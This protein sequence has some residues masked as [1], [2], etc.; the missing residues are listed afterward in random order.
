MVNCSKDQSAGR[1]IPDVDA[2]ATSS[3]CRFTGKSKKKKSIACF[4]KLETG[5]GAAY[6]TAGPLRPFLKRSR[7]SV[8]ALRRAGC[9]TGSTN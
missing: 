3:C 5:F 7:D 6:R 2:F 8:A 4:K 9:S 1:S